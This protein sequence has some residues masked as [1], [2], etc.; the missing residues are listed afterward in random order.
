MKWYD[1][2][3]KTALIL[4]LA[5]TAAKAQDV[6]DKSTA[7]QELGALRGEQCARSP[8]AEKIFGAAVGV[9]RAMP[10]KGSREA[11][12]NVFLLMRHELGGGEGVSR[13]PHEWPA[14]TSLACRSVNGCVEAAKVFFALFRTAYPR[15]PALYLDSFNSECPSGGH[16]VV[17]VSDADGSSFIADAVSYGNVPDRLVA[18]RTEFSPVTEEQMGF[19]LDIRP[20]YQGRIVQVQ[21]E[22]DFYISEKGGKY[23]VERYP[24]AS[25]FSGKP[26]AVSFDSLS[27]VNGHLKDFIDARNAGKEL[28]FEDLRK[29]GLILA[30]NEPRKTSFQYANWCQGGKARHVV[31]GCRAKVSDEDDADAVEPGL[32]KRFAAMGIADGCDRKRPK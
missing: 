31:F 6:G 22:A 32:R 3:M 7:L 4:L 15:F 25:V 18:A 24:Y 1:D 9:L 2:A 21:D 14:R 28:A 19:T 26:E 12:V 11:V 17:E 8:L 20:E 23:L 27:R 10:A 16:A 5:A 13:G 30:F 29:A